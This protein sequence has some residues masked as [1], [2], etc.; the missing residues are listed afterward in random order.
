MFTSASSMASLAQSIAAASPGA[1]AALRKRPLDSPAYWSLPF[2]SERAWDCSDDDK[3]AVVS[4]I[5]ILTP[6][7]AADAR[8]SA[9]DPAVPFGRALHR[10]DVALS[11]VVRLLEARRPERRKSLL[12]ICRLVASKGACTRFRLDELANIILSDDRDAKRNVLKEYVFAG[13]NKDNHDEGSE[14]QQ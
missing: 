11:R 8:R 13:A 14:N 12:T 3:A 1:A 9:Y 6:R 5:A 4:A 10:S 2:A 7:G